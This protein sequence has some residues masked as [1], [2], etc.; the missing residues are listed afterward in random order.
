ML[1]NYMIW[2]TFLNI[3]SFV[4]RTFFVI[5]WRGRRTIR[6]YCNNPERDCDGLSQE[7][8]VVKNG[9]NLDL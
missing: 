4:Y 2:F 6:S 8:E 9:Q 1:R 7:V 5:V 3:H